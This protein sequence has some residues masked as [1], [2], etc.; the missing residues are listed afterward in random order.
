MACRPVARI[1]VWGVVLSFCYFLSVGKEG[2][3]GGVLGHAHAHPTLF[4]T[5]VLLRPYVRFQANC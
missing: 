3:G 2:G 5:I 1:F 4:L